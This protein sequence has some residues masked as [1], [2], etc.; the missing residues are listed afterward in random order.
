MK[1]DPARQ[2]PKRIIDAIQQAGNIALF[3]HTHPD[4]D[5]LGSLLGFADILRDCN[6]NVLCYL[7]EPVSY[8][9]D[10]LPH[11][12][13]V[14][15]GLEAYQEFVSQSG[16][17]LLNIALD[18]GDDD[19]L[20]ILK[21][22]FLKV[23]PFVVIDHHQSHKNF[24]TDRWVDS[25]KSST[26]EMVFEIAQALGVDMSYECAY[27][28]YIAICTDTGSFKYEN[29]RARTMQ[30]AGELLDK[31]V[32]PEQVGNHL[33]DNYSKPRLKLLE[34]VLST[35][36]F[37]E[38]DQ[39]AFIYVDDKMLEQSGATMQDVE[40][41]IDFPRSIKAVQVAVFIKETRNKGISV[42]FRAKGTCDVA[43][44]AK[45]FAG[46]GHRNAAGFKCE[47]KTLAEVREGVYDVLKKRLA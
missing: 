37:R 33:Y 23:E 42:S 35:V 45:H 3:T 27:N 30:I 12:D 34:L 32:L 44:V 7:E 21:N 5:A 31:G 2:V 47:G 17:D 39:L 18:C 29:T 36:E 13:E 24:G 38:S 46:G 9:Y 22:E 40:G 43:E 14:Q 26:G 19:R 4:G 25:T 6:K 10:F 8:L 11:S 15:I 1:E 28:L 16:D 20:G 41:F